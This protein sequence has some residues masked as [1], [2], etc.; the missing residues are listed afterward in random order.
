MKNA[1]YTKTLNSIVNKLFLKIKDDNFEE[2]DLEDEN[3]VSTKSFI[4]KLNML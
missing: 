3:K 1:I 2:L 4:Q